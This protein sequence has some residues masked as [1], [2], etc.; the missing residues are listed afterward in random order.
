MTLKLIESLVRQNYCNVSRVKLKK[1]AETAPPGSTTSTN[2]EERVR[3]R[4]GEIILDGAQWDRVDSSLAI[5]TIIDEYNRYYG[6]RIFSL[7]S[8][9]PQ[10]LSS[11]RRTLAEW[12][13]IE[14][15]FS[16]QKL[17]EIY[18]RVHTPD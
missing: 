17:I 7:K 8:S 16:D 13:L 10:F 14:I 18:C 15:K 6:A 5:R 1:G 12:N 2:F 9:S 4:L 11:L 3:S